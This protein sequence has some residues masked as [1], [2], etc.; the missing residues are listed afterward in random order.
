MA[1]N[2]PLHDKSAL[3]TTVTDTLGIISGIFVIQR[4]GY[5]LWAKL[6]FGLDDWLCLATIVSGVPSTV[7]DTYGIASNGLGRDVW[8][9][10][11]EQITDFGR[12]FFIVEVLYFFEVTTLKLS[13]LFFYIRIFPAKRSQRLL[14]GTV[15]FAILF[16]VAFVIAS[17]FQCTPVSYFWT[18]WD[19]EH[20][21]SCMDLNALAWSN[22]AI[23]IALDAWML[24][25]PLWELRGL[26]LH[27]KRKVGVALM[28][29]VG[30]L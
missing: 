4:F 25:I 7:L 13:L 15:V 2:D 22:A 28:F 12:S 30:T 5:K 16:G 10:R 29:C 11:Y 3:Y 17:I 1:C 24:A 18:K 20:K 9:V 6:D 23:S 21:G 27:W 14:W 26:Q 8:T 19:N